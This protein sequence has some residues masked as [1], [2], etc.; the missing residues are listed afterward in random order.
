MKKTI[1]IMLLMSIYIIFYRTYLSFRSEVAIYIINP[2]VWITFGIVSYINLRSNRR[3]KTKT[4]TGVDS[5]ITV[6]SLFYVIFYYGLGVTVGYTNNPY[7]TTLSGIIINL[8]SIVLVSCLK[9]YIRYLFMHIRVMFHK[10]TYYFL[11]F[12]IFLL[13][14]INIKNI[15][16]YD[17]FLNL[18]SKELIIP[19]I[20]NLLM[21]Y[22]SNIG[23]LRAPITSRI[24]LLLPWV[25]F[26]A[27]PDYDW[28]VILILNIIYYLL[29]YLVVQYIVGKNDRTAPLGILK[30]INPRK[31]LITLLIII[32]I[33]AFGA[34][35]FILK[36]VV[37]L[38]GSMEPL[39]S[40]GD[41]SIIRK[42][43]IND[44]KIGD[45]IEYKISDYTVVHRVIA[46][47]YNYG[48]TN[49]ITKGD[50]NKDADSSP[51]TSE[52]LIGKLEYNIPYVG[53]P[54]YFLRNIVNNNKEV[55]IEIGDDNND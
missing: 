14:D 20:S 39:I 8:F 13:S 52:Q 34:G 5:S 22:L 44:I 26:T 4:D 1:V 17:N 32:S 38:T 51:V 27:V 24:I 46:I 50:A 21:M 54:A 10:K 42:C 9:E 37:I 25:L 23:T 41:M 12:F 28:S 35:F 19:I 29:T 36:P 43:S 7:A 18:W 33:I 2:L 47:N 45:I 48:E 55:D 30:S 53:Y 15:V 11:L 49:L 31:G 3:I 40:A 16:Q 6:L